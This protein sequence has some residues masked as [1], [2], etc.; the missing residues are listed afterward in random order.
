MRFKKRVWQLLGAD[1]LRLCVSQTYWQNRAG[2]RILHCPQL[3]SMLPGE[4]WPA[5]TASSG[6]LSASLSQ[7][8]LALGYS[9]NTRGWSPQG[10][11]DVIPSIWPYGYGSKLVE[12]LHTLLVGH[13]GPCP[14]V[15]HTTET[16]L[17]KSGAGTGGA[18]VRWEELHHQAG[19]IWTPSEKNTKILGWKIIS[20][21]IFCRFC[22]FHGKK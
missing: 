14:E 2:A 21:T 20:Q 11:G 6:W 1:G 8:V 3:S 19:R 10:H 12:T 5:R 17:T 9:R 16:C 4:M 13:L 22:G 7:I 18:A 15:S